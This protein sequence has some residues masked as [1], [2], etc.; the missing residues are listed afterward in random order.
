MNQKLKYLRV[1]QFELLFFMVRIIL[2]ELHM[3]LIDWVR[4][5]ASEA[6]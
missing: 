5:R 1:S 6:F 2:Y 4:A 3:S